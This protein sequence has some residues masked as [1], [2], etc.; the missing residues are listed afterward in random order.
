AGERL[1]VDAALIDAAVE[2]DGDLVAVLRPGARRFT[3]GVDHGD[4]AAGAEHEGELDEAGQVLAAGPGGAGDV[5]PARRL[6]GRLRGVPGAR[7]AV[8]RRRPGAAA[9]RIPHRIGVADG[10]EELVEQ[11]AHLIKRRIRIDVRALRRDAP[12]LGVVGEIAQV[13][14]FV[15]PLQQL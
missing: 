5:L 4:G 8:A 13:S 6:F 12:A 11:H 7:I 14:L 15:V 9:Q 3:L 1:A 10:L 2:G